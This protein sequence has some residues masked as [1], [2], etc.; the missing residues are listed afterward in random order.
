MGLLVHIVFV[1]G[2]YFVSILVSN[3]FMTG[4][5]GVSPFYPVAP[6][7]AAYFFLYGPRMSWVI[8]TVKLGY[9][10]VTGPSLNYMLLVTPPSLLTST[11]ALGIGMVMRSVVQSWRSTRLPAVVIRVFLAVLIIPAIVSLI[12]NWYAVSFFA[13][14]AKDYLSFVSNFAVGDSASYLS[15]TSLYIL[16][17]AAAHAGLSKFVPGLPPLFGG[18]GFVRKMLAETA[19]AFRAMLP[20][21]IGIAGITVLVALPGHNLQHC[22]Y[23]ILPPLIL[24]VMKARLE[25]AMILSAAISLLLVAAI[26]ITRPETAASAVFDLQL[27]L[28]CLNLLTF[29]SG[30]FASDNAARLERLR[31]QQRDLDI[32]NA[33]KLRILSGLGDVLE[34]PLHAVLEYSKELGRAREVT[35]AAQ[36]AL[37]VVNQLVEYNDLEQAHREPESV[38][39][40]RPLV[41][42]SLVRAQR[43]GGGDK[44]QTADMIFDLDPEFRLRVPPQA[45]ALLLD[46][47]FSL[48]LRLRRTPESPWRVVADVK[49]GRPRLT[50]T[51]FEIKDGIDMAALDEIS[52]PLSGAGEKGLPGGYLLSLLM[53]RRMT[54]SIGGKFS[55]VPH[56]L[57]GGLDIRLEAGLEAVE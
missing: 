56:L 57:R 22:W 45:Y 8:Y 16:I 26:R 55:L 19:I 48:G 15:L 39:R 51:L 49:N 10:V 13:L 20:Y 3:E 54:V 23:L 40:M 52:S 6:L 5:P 17:F 2:V 14:P 4:T 41:Y 27:F 18:H 33:A 25:G 21:L 34:R 28:I 36:Q 43:L 38:V 29:I 50:M 37:A 11:G 42:R 35:E 30:A 53:L 24:G 7:A 32:A 12:Y 9:H 44:R 46:H 31:E 47:L 1:V